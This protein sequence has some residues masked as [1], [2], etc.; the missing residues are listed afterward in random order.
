MLR[1]GAGAGPKRAAR[2]ADR[3]AADVA[4][5]GWPVG[6]V[7]GSEADLLAHYEV[8][9][10]V[11]REAVRLVEHQQVVRTR[12]GPGGGLVITE[13]TKG[14]VVDAVAQYL[15][16]VGARLDEVFDA[17]I[18]LEGLASGLAAERFA[19]VAPREPVAAN[20]PN[21]ADVGSSEFH[22]WVA[23]GSGNACLELLVN[24]LCDV[25]RR[26][27]TQG[28]LS[29]SAPGRDV[30]N[31]HVG[32]ADAIAAGNGGLACN[33]MQK[34]LANRAE[35]SRRRRS[36]RQLLPASSVRKDSVAAKKGEV[37]ALSLSRF[38]LSER[39]QPGQLVG[40]ERE[41]LEREGVS[42][43]L[44]REA[45]RLLEHQQIAHMKRGPGGGLFVT[46]PGPDAVYDMAAIYLARRATPRADVAA[47]RLTVEAA[48]AALAAERW[49]EE[50]A[51]GVEQALSRGELA[52]DAEWAIA[53]D[54]FHAAVAGATRNKV[55]LLVV[56]VLIRLSQ[57]QRQEGSA[58]RGWNAR[59]SRGGRGAPGYRPC[60]GRSAGGHGA[61]ARAS[62][63]G[64]TRPRLTL[65]T[66]IFLSS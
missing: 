66:G 64:H 57:R 34:H 5:M 6:E 23:A 11:F 2:V 36:T 58:A 50:S 63:P 47:C 38:I 60:A 52:S 56:L 31:E 21:N 29:A 26:Y 28:E 17:R 55:L 13:P 30:R 65:A 44:L 32:I 62:A 33:R 61:G 10:A 7:L 9:R 12:R 16:Q 22:T 51:A 54:E 49:D 27:S 3:I 41:L 8:S 46:A 39:L 35:Q 37:V 19:E 48:T 40:T 14:A 4:A 59:E 42:R 1:P 24:V 45:V 18:V 15:R 25:T 20:L 53:G 43:A